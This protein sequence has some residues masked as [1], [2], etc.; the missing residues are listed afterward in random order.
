MM[1]ADLDGGR[2]EGVREGKEGQGEREKYE[3]NTE[4]TLG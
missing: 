3:E 2:R 4:R 1:I